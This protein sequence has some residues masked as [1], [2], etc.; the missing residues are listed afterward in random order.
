MT[1]TPLPASLDSEKA[2]LGGILL[3][4]KAYIEASGS[5]TAD[6][7]SCDSH[8]RIFRRMVDLMEVGRPCD[9]VTLVEEIDCTQRPQASWR[10][11]LHCQSN[12]WLA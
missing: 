10:C 11:G 7:F 9:S 2:V 12:R 8:R 4:N 6:D 1:D 3:D 5:L